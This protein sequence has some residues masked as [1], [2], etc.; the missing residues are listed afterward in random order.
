MTGAEVHLSRYCDA[1]LL[2][3]SRWLLAAAYLLVI[4]FLTVYHTVAHAV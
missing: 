4:S 1:A 2:A 3:G